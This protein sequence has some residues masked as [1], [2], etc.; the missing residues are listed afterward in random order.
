[1]KPQDLRANAFVIDEVTQLQLP[2]YGASGE[3]ANA[4]RRPR[5]P[6]F[7]IFKFAIFST[8]EKMR[9][10][11]FIHLQVLLLFTICILEK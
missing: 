2:T 10:S 5:P 8:N 6:F 4:Q 1:M 11:A 9:K 7:V 3:G